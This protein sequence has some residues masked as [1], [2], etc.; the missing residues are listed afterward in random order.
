MAQ[1]ERVAEFKLTWYDSARAGRLAIVTMDNGED[2]RRPN[3]LGAR[4]IESI[5]RTLDE[6]EAQPDCKGLLLTGKP[7]VFAVGADI[8][9]FEGATPEFA[10]A[11]TAAG[12][13]ALRRLAALPLP[14]LAAIN[15]AAIG[16]GMDVALH[17]DYRTLSTSAAPLAFSE[18]FLSI[19]PAWGGTQVTSRLI[20]G[21]K[22]LEVVV[23]NALDNNRMLKAAEAFELG[24]ADRLIPSVEFLD[25][26]VEQLEAI[27]T[28]DEL[29]ERRAPDEG[30]LDDALARARAFADDK[31]HGATRAPY[32][33]I[34]LIEFAARGGDLDEGY[35]REQVAMAELLPARQ[36]QASIYSF[37]LTQQ[38]V[39]KQPWRP[40]AQPRR[41]RKVAIVGSGLMGAQLGALFLQRLEVPVV[42]KDIDQGI[43]DNARVHIDGEVDKLVQ[44]GRVNAGKGGFLKSLVTY[45]LDDADVAG[46]DFVLEAVLERMDLKQQVFADVEKVVDETAVL[47]TNTSSLSVSE[48]VAGLA[49]PER[50]VGLHFFNPVAVLPFIEIVKTDKA[51]DEALATAF[52]VSKQLR[53]SG[54]LCAD[55]PAFVVNR[56]LTR[57]NAAGIDALRH[58]SS[59]AEIDDAVKELGLPMG[60]FEL[61][62]LV[63]IKVAFHTAETLH[64]A[65]PARFPIDETF[66]GLAELGVPGI[67]DWSKGRVPYDEVATTVVVEE[68]AQRLSAEEIRQR[69]LEAV[70]QEA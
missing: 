47:A 20:G 63:G 31:V 40:D 56:L 38:R 65:Y 14:T 59:F 12:Q 23:H 6:V 50:V 18:V 43:L 53:K 24:F 11:G 32:V 34:D 13:A 54:V 17:C 1:R 9:A 10:R 58:G 64:A 60:P 61:L 26:S 55:T 22:A 57:F 44:R 46:A 35:R 51:S 5:N 52:E 68:G 30:D 42:M 29:L 62:G 49:H 7:F 70:T 39:K 67:Y 8:N 4:S 21:A 41:V 2:H 27:V 28:G 15:G 19:F 37:R 16:G 33:A 3:T 48:M 45:T 36:A 25:K 69:A 66:R